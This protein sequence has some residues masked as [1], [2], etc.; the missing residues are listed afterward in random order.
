MKKFRIFI[1]AFFLF[2]IVNCTLKIKDCPSQ[3]LYQPTGASGTPYD[4]KF[5]DANTGI[6][7]TNSAT[8]YR[9]TNGGQ[10]WVNI[11]TIR[12]FQFEL[13]DSMVCYCWARSYSGNDLILRTFNK[14]ETWDSVAIAPIVYQGLSFINR[15]TGWV[16]GFDG[17]NA[18][19][20]RT[21]NGG[22][23]LMPQI[24]NIGIGKIFFH[25][26][27]INGEYHG[28]C[29]H[30]SSMY[31]TT[32]SGVN[33][34][35]IDWFWGYS[36][37]FQQ[38][39]MIDENTGWASTGDTSIWKTT[40]GGDNWFKQFMPNIPNK[41]SK[42]IQKITVLNSNLIYGIGGARWFGPGIVKGI[43]WKTINGGLN[44]GFQQP[45]TSYPI[46][47]YYALDFIDSIKGW[48]YGLSSQGGVHTTN[49]GGQIIYTGI[50][51]SSN[52]TPEEF[53]LYQNYPNPFN[54]STAIE[55]DVPKNAVISL[56]L[57]DILGREIMKI[58]DA[59]EIIP[60][61]YKTLIDLNNYNFS[62]GIYFYRLTAFE[63]VSGNIFQISKKMIYSK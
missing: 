17:N 59:K 32:S 58:I 22:E 51:N 11:K 36:I 54:S 3:W 55:F 52:E 5:F 61:S 13:I 29:S 37:T 26:K 30:N 18:V 40:T 35:L 27:K 14:G 50:N 24:Y 41:Y 15:D 33:W 34:F 31:K 43:I 7:S 42:S 48:A 23:T 28:W 49:G 19:I 20:W 38:I 53:K 8:L 56:I 12:V 1:F 46:S 6:I 60:G 62:G 10:N 16:S 39:A 63:K 9:T 44:W 47:R 21:T 2:F 45:D 57:Y 25:K 4:M